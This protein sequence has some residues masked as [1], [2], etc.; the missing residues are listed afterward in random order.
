MNAREI[1][2]VILVRLHIRKVLPAKYIHGKKCVDCQ[3]KLVPLCSKGIYNSSGGELYGRQS[4]VAKIV[5]IADVLENRGLAIKVFE[6]YRGKDKQS[7]MRDSQ[8]NK[9]QELYPKYTDRQIISLLNKRISP[10][11]GGHQTG[12]AI[13]L[14]ICY[15]D[16]EELDMGT[17]YLEFNESTPTSSRKLTSAQKKNRALLLSVMKD[18]GFVNY[19]LEW[20]HY[21]YGDKM[22]AAYSNSS[23]AVYGD[24]SNYI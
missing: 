12:G 14:T 6:F 16:G 8:K 21:S 1:Y 4:V 18:A 9:I 3:E 7:A 5:Q 2:N 17:S 11:G 22:W 24:I 19:P 10:E 15:Q 20:W 13:D 23:T